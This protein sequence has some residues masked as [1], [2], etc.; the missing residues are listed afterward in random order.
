MRC[1][2]NRINLDL[3]VD[4]D[5]FARRVQSGLRSF[6]SFCILGGRKTGKTALLKKIASESVDPLIPVYLNF[7]TAPPGIDLRWAFDEIARATNLGGLWAGDFV[8]SMIALISHIR[9]H[10]QTLVILLDEV[11]LLDG[12]DW[13]G[14]FFDNLNHLIFTND[15]TS[16]NICIVMAGG[17]FL[18]GSPQMSP[19]SPLLIRL[20]MLPLKLFGVAETKEL[21]TRV[22][23]E[24]ITSELICELH[25]ATAG[26]PALLQ[27]FL[28]KLE[29]A[30]WEASIESI[31]AALGG[32]ASKLCES[33]FRNTREHDLEIY[34][35][36]GRGEL[37]L[38][39]APARLR[40]VRDSLARL[41]FLGLVGRTGDSQGR[42]GPK[43]FRAWFADW[44]NPAAPRDPMNVL[45]MDK[46]E[47]NFLEFKSTFAADLNR[48]LSRK[49]VVRNCDVAHE[50]PI[51]V[52]GFLNAG[53]GDI[54]VGVCEP[55]DDGYQPALAEFPTLGSK[56]IVGLNL[57]QSLMKGG[58]DEVIGAFLS[59]LKDKVDSTVAAM[60]KIAPLEIDGRV[61]AHIRVPRGKKFYY[62]DRRFYVRIH[63]RTQLLPTE[64]AIEYQ[65]SNPR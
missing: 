58:W 65:K 25:S 11:E 43:V 31:G 64:E 6:E 39:T 22:A 24:R 4:R 26:H 45:R 50:V 17:T 28:G 10:H 53:G 44:L 55:K 36:L 32:D 61:V 37:I 46:D 48:F 40:E 16:R 38:P 60:F 18:D 29:G 15:S 57:D 1:D 34:A 63:N 59:L 7:Q 20:T 62:F 30:N 56:K 8:R 41:S 3:F 19:C 51:A 33:V 54:F 42:L 49:E 35:D 21:C 5:L 47:D 52:V 9:T 2:W 12:V 13:A 27:Y 23:G 14:T